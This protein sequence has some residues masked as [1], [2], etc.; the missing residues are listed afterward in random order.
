MYT[1]VFNKDHCVGVTGALNG[2]R[3][4]ANPR[5]EIWRA[6]RTKGGWFNPL[7]ENARAYRARIR[8]YIYMYMYRT[9]RVSRTGVHVGMYRVIVLTWR[10]NFCLEIF[11]FQ[12][13]FFNGNRGFC[14]TSLKCADTGP[15]GFSAN[16]RVW[17][18]TV[19]SDFVDY[20][21]FRIGP[22]I[23]QHHWT[24][25]I[26]SFHTTEKW[27]A[28]VYFDIFFFFFKSYFGSFLLLNRFRFIRVF[29]LLLI[30]CFS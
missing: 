15:C 22:F 4:R 21:F 12:R 16:F 5:R 26:I 6:G 14:L 23:K 29:T 19:S 27:Y 20:C 24:L 10:F 2:D 28:Y 8:I 30:F 18:S 17:R 25:S 11:L 1:S 7:R 13:R 9:S 3:E